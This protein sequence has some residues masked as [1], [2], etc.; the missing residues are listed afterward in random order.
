MLRAGTYYT[1]GI[2]L[3]SVHSGLTIQN[4]HGEDAVVTGAVR[5]PVSP[6][7]GRAVDN[8]QEHSSSSCG[9]STQQSGRDGCSRLTA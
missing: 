1:K 9:D 7:M 4:Y 5:V 6:A 2:V 3:S 8:L